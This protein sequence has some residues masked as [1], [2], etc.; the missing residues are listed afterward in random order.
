M[1]S[2]NEAH[3]IIHSFAAAHA[4]TAFAMA[5]IP[6][7]DTAALTAE[8]ISMVSIIVARCGNSWTQAAIESFVAQQLAQYAGVTAASEFSRFFPGFSNIFRACTSCAI[9]EAIGWATYE[10]CKVQSARS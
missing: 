2:K 8:T 4:G 7:A 3:A 5:Q 9:T 6:F 10:A 1:I